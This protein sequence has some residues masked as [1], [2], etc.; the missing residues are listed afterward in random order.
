MTH[1]Q[2]FQKKLCEKAEAALITSPQ[3]QFYLSHFPFEDGFLLV[4]PDVAY[5]LTD[6]RYLEAAT[7]TCADEFEILSPETGAFSEI[8]KR[9]EAHG[10]TTLLVEESNLTLGMQA[11]INE[12]FPTLKTVIGASAILRSL[13]EFKDEQEMAAIAAAQEITDAAFTHI[14]DFICK[15]RTE[16]EVAL[17]LEVFMRKHG[18][19]GTAFQTIA[20]SGTASALPHGVPRDCPLENGFLTMDF[21]ARYGGY[22]ADMTRTVMIGR[23]DAEQKRLY[24]TVLKAQKAALTVIGGGQSCSAM[25][26]VARDIIHGAGFVGCFGHSLGH[27]VGIDV[28][29]APSLSSRAPASALLTPGQIVTVEPGIYL[30]GKYG[31]RIEDMVAINEDGSV[32]NF[33]K[34][35]K[36]LIEICR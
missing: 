12:Q 8:G 35:S 26:K 36:E 4:F 14:L 1:L 22:C 32:R 18:A 19:E 28:H 24:E 16:R 30:L 29:E 20:V 6:F 15:E 27:G 11:R 7:K 34:S 25:D 5:L 21:G 13:R 2:A 31:C 3:N 9:M 10:A 17:E 33:T 23:A